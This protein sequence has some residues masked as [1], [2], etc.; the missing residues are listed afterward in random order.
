MK[1]SPLSMLRKATGVTGDP[2]AIHHLTSTMCFELIP[3]KNLDA[4]IAYLPPATRIS[5]TC[6][7]AKGIAATQEITERLR[8]MGHFPIPHISARLVTGA[9]HVLEL[10]RWFKTNAIDEM[11]LVGGDAEQPGPYLEALTFLKEFLGHD[12]GVKRIGVTAYPDG[13]A[14]IDR[15]VLQK[16]LHDKQMV[17][18][19]ANL[20]GWASTQM[21][22]DSTTIKTWLAAERAA[23]LTLPIHLGIPGVI[24]RT[25]LLTMGV[26]LGVGS[27]IRYAK[28]NRGT[29]GQLFSPGGYDPLQLLQPV[30]LYAKSLNV[31]ALHVFTFNNVDATAAWR[32]RVLEGPAS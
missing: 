30:S 26:R 2:V 25:K 22:L 13:H 1:L 14:L 5:V 12:H 9:D 8:D 17:L 7:P 15:P 21:C 29:L 18:K 24:D 10:A 20:Q 23:G 19:E 3:L 28:K 4:Q 6:S 31:E 27:S 32:D 11:F 16:A